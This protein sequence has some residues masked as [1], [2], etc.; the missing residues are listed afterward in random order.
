MTM[1]EKQR[2]DFQLSLARIRLSMLENDKLLRKLIEDN[3]PRMDLMTQKLVNNALNAAQH[4]RKL[5][6]QLN[7]SLN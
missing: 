6:A 1:T 4:Q 2:D 5:L 7:N 3:K